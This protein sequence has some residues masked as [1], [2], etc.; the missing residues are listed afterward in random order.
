MATVGVHRA[1]D[2]IVLQQI[3][4]PSAPA[5]TG[6]PPPG[7]RDSGQAAST[8]ALTSVGTSM[9]PVDVGAMG[10]AHDMHDVLFFVD[11]VGTTSGRVV[12]GQL[13]L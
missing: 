12:A 4:R 1:K 2:H 7:R 11:P 9:R 10:Y 3:S 8:A 13:P 5:S 6:H